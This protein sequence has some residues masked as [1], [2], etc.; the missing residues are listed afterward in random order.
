MSNVL[1]YDSLLI[2]YLAEELDERLRGRRLQGLALDP[3]RRAAVLELEDYA[4]S[5]RLHPDAGWVTPGRAELSP[6]V[7]PLARRTRVAAVTAPL[8]ERVLV[9]ELAAAA[10]QAGR[11]TR[12]VVELL[13][14]QWNLIA[15][16]PDERI[17]AVLWR[18]RAGERELRPGQLYLPAP[19]AGRRGAARPLGPEEWLELLGGVPPGERARRLIA[20]VAYTSPINAAAILGAAGREAGGDAGMPS[21]GDAQ[22]ALAAAYA[23]YIDLASLPPASPRLLELGAARQPYPLP[24]PGIDDAPFPTLLAAMVAGAGEAPGAEVVEAAAVPLD[25]LDRLRTRIRWLERRR[26]RLA[27]ELDDAVLSAG[28][29]RHQAD[30]LMAQ[31]HL[32]RKGMAEAQLPDWEGGTVSVAL[33]PALGPSENAQQLYARARKEARAAERV[34]QLL[35]RV[36]SEVEGLRDLLERAE[37]GEA[38]AEEV[39]AAVPAPAAEGRG[40]PGRAAVPLLPYRRYRTAGG[41]EVRV[42]RSSRGNDELTFR[43][44]SPNDVWLHARDVAGAHVILRWGDAQANPP[45]RDLTEAA[46]LASLH[47][48]A[49]TSGLVAVDWTR[50]KYVRKPRKSGPGRVAIERA[51]TLF[52]EPDAGVE[53][54]LREGE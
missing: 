6:E 13:G 34:P 49:R 14:N 48:R 3:E 1:R 31:L 36:V 8:D 38:G 39:R 29:L 24:L 44:S 26:A 45:A 4:L 18:R 37:R 46:V 22:E 32:V 28:S 51:R 21:A 15:V 12:I 35:Q 5:W 43:H 40:G 7:V 19:A 9:F 52:V 23:R 2:R 17:V 54:R 50:R 33:D 47:S 27:T 11:P 25:L 41:L 20:E 16:G 53:R 42:G 10:R 30:L